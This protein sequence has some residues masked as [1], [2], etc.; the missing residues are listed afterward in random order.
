MHVCSLLF[1]NIWFELAEGMLG[2]RGLEAQVA[3]VLRP[4]APTW[5][6]R[7]NHALWALARGEAVESDV[8][9]QFG[10]RAPSSWELFSPRWREDPDQMRALSRG[11]RGRPDPLIGA[12]EAA[13]RADALERQLPASVRP[14]V[15]LTRRYLRLREDQRF[16]FDRLLWRWKEAWLWLE[17]DTGLSLRF[18]EADE[19]EALLSGDLERERAADLVARREAA[20]RGEHRRRS[21]GDAPPVF[22]VGEAAA[23]APAGGARLSGQGISAG[24]VRG[25]VRVI[26]RLADGAQLRA[27]EILVA[28]ATDPGWT[29]LFG[30]AAGLVLEMGG[31][32]SHGAVVAREY[33]LPGVVNVADATRR[34]SD[35]QVV[36]VDGGRGLVFVH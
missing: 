35:G 22:L 28:A 24:V 10:H 9:A 11:L 27:G 4:S 29:P 26:H 30:R 25:T 1:A 19:A 23:D 18:L 6:A 20:W 2:A 13:E 31:M 32:L 8:L 36:T 21:E 14:V 7:T 16:H 5:T 34:L 17:R 3:Q 15:R 12:T 33:G